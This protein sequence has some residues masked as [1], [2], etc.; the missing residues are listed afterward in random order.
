MKG[1][2][3]KVIET[4]RGI[5]D[6]EGRW[7]ES[8]DVR[9]PPP[10]WDRNTFRWRADTLECGHIITQKSQF[11]TPKA[12]GSKNCKECLK[13]EKESSNVRQSDSKAVG[14]SE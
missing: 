4:R 11:G 1:T 14:N 12:S 7:V 2:L 3:K 13:D 6:K 5:I 9:N 10:P 8:K